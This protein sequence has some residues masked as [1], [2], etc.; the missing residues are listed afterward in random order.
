M[1]SAWLLRYITTERT[2]QPAIVL[3]NTVDLAV[4]IKV[5]HLALG[6]QT[7]GIQFATGAWEN[8]VAFKKKVLKLLGACVGIDPC[9]GV[10]VEHALSSEHREELFPHL[11]WLHRPNPHHGLT[12]DTRSH[13]SSACC[14]KPK[15]LRSKDQV[16]DLI[17]RFHLLCK[18]RDWHVVVVLHG[19]DVVL[20]FAGLGDPARPRWGVR[21]CELQLGPARAPRDAL[22]RCDEERQRS[23]GALTAC[24]LHQCRPI[25][26]QGT[27]HA[28]V[29]QATVRRR[30]CFLKPFYFKF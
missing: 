18:R 29:N 11:V 19:G 3:A 21:V 12:I 27:N 25:M 30:T 24:A 10:A 22:R 17:M 23:M 1:P 7:L 16:D 14:G 2:C 4:P 26:L 9:V 5:A 8:T 13:Q 28:R 20:L 6:Q 15:D